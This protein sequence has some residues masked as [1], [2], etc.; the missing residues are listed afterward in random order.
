[1][2]DS[3]EQ[4]SAAIALIAS[5]A[6]SSHALALS[7]SSSR[8]TEAR[9][10]VSARIETAEWRRILPSAS[11]RYGELLNGDLQIGCHGTNRYGNGGTLIPRSSVPCSDSEYPY[12]DS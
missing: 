10:I 11:T 1:M 6:G 8:S 4:T 12:S 9:A 5:S 7:L 3:R 2:R